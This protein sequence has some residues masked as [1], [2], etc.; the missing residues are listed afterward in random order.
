MTKITHK[1]NIRLLGL[2]ILA[3]VIGWGSGFVSNFVFLRFV[4]ETTSEFFTLFVILLLFLQGIFWASVVGLGQMLV[5]QMEKVPKA[6]FWGATPFIG[7]SI[8]FLNYEHLL[9][10]I[11]AS[12]IGGAVIGVGQWLILHQ[13]APRRAWIWVLTTPFIFVISIGLPRAILQFIWSIDHGT[14]GSLQHWG[15]G[16]GISFALAASLL[17][18]IGTGIVLILILNGKHQDELSNR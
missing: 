9:E 7:A 11:W 4:T 8:I 16:L 18:G 3:T 10:M 17:M 1:K 15:L 12:L 6:I 2:W 5:L 14:R 13:T